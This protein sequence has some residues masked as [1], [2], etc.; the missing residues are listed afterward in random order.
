MANPKCSCGKLA[1]IVYIN[2]PLSVFA[3]WNFDCDVCKQHDEDG[4]WFF[5]NRIATQAKAL[6]WT[7]HLSQ[8]NWFPNT[9]SSWS[10][11]LTELFPE[12]M[13]EEL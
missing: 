3:K 10:F 11:I 2:T 13:G 12:V 9:I 4:Y 1:T 8:K 6:N 5:I 7:R